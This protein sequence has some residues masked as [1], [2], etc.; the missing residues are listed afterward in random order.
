MKISTHK[1]IRNS[2]RMK[3]IK[4]L[5]YDGFVHEY[6]LNDIGELKDK[7][8]KSPGR[9]LIDE[10]N[11]IINTAP[12]EIELPNVEPFVIELTNKNPMDEFEKVTF[13]EELSIEEEIQQP[14]INNI[15]HDINIPHKLYLL[16]ECTRTGEPINDPQ[17]CY[18]ETNNK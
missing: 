13:D 5:E 9:H 12:V 4:C 2:S 14:I 6:E 10:L 3:K 18:V 8:E 17:W 15:L 7:F 16:Q 11:K 1:K